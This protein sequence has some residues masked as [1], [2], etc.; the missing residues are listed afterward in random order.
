[1][2]SKAE[3]KFDKI[4]KEG[5][6]ATLKPLGFKKKGSN[7]YFY[8]NGIGQIINLQKSQFYSK[9]NIHFTINTAIFL[10]EFWSEFYN[11]FDKPIPGYPIESECILR[12][13]IGQLRNENDVWHDIVE[14]TE[15][16]DLIDEMKANLSRYILPHFAQIATKQM[17]IEFLDRQTM[18]ATLLEKLIVFGEL[19]DM[20]RTRKEFHKLLNDSGNAN[21]LG[22][23]H[24]YGRKYGLI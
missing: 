16:N 12:L 21:Y 1:M 3:E 22:R 18:G 4:V 5:F 19:G 9:S 13:R 2:K 23:I 14:T 11:Y 20:E 10:P 8:S 17:L 24:E 7:F 6:H 15:E